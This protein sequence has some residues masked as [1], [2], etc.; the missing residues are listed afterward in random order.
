MKP[1]KIM[2][3]SKKVDFY[4]EGGESIISEKLF[5]LILITILSCVEIMEGKKS[6]RASELI[7]VL[8]APKDSVLATYDNG[9]PI[10][11]EQL[12]V[13][14]RVYGIQSKNISYATGKAKGYYGKWFDNW[15]DNLMLKPVL[16]ASSLLHLCNL[17]KLI[18]EDAFDFQ[19]VLKP[20]IAPTK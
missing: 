16:N 6:M 20:E 17:P 18:N 8:C 5:R 12:D 2:E 15:K 10:T 7:E 9:K 4:N 14:L 1:H 19:S 3:L 11:I 13:L